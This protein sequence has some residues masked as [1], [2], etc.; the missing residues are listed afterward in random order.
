MNFF[1]GQLANKSSKIIIKMNSW[2]N[3]AIF[4]DGERRMFYEKRCCEKRY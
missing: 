3:P 1:T 2:D 4:L